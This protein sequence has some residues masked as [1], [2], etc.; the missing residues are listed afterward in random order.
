MADTEKK[1]RVHKTPEQRQAEILAAATKVFAA[2]GYQVADTQAIADL[3]AVG[4]GTL[5]RY[6]PTKETLFK[7]ALKRQLDILK[8]RLETAFHTTGSP[9]AKIKAV[10][11]AYFLFFDEHPETIELFAQERAEFGR[12]NTPLYFERI[13]TCNAG[14]AALFDDIKANHPAR[15]MSTDAMM[16]RCSELMHGAVYV[17]LRNATGLSAYQ[18]LDDIYEFYL[19]GIL[20]TQNPVQYVQENT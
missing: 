3:A 12:E 1:K 14:W 18:Q 17:S 15:E 2:R 5:Y 19:F 8:E 13:Y 6:F 10:M 20:D 7:E 9:F 4:K 11:G 16:V